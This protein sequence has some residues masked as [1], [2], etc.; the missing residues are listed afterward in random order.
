MM[1]ARGK[2]ISP[3]AVPFEQLQYAGLANDTGA[4]S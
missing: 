1:E 4:S 2:G 3:I